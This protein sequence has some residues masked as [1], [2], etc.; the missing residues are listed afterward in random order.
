MYNQSGLDLPFDLPTAKKIVR[1]IESG[2][3]VQFHHVELVYTDQNKITEINNTYLGRDY[4]TDIIS[5]RYDEDESDQLIEGTLYC[6]A[7]RIIEQSR[8]FDATTDA[9]FQ[10][11]FIH[12]LLHLAGYDDQAPEDKTHMTSL[13]DRYLQSVSL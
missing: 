10:R 7:P 13:E 4:I 2:E 5:F 11:V 12:G 9:E 1:E 8:E 3:Q 6:C